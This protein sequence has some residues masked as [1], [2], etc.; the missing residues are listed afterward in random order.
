MEYEELLKQIS[1]FP[2]A[3]DRGKP[4]F[5]L[6]VPPSPQV[7]TPGR[8]FLLKTP[9]EGASY[10]STVLKNAGYGVEIVDYRH[11]SKPLDEVLSGDRIVLGIGTTM[12]SYP[13][14]E[15]F[16]RQVKEKNKDIVIILGGAF[17]SSAPSVLMNSIPADYAVIGEGE[18]TMLE[19]MDALSRPGSRRIPDIPGLAFR[20]N[21]KV[22]FSPA[23]QQ[24]KD[25]DNL[26]IPDFG[27]WP[28]VKSGMNL[29]RLGISSSRGCYGKCSFCFKTIPQVRQ[30]TPARFAELVKYCVK[31]HGLKFA[32]I[33]DLTFVIGRK[34]TVEL[35]RELKKT[36]I[37]WATSTRAQDVDEELLGIL[38]D[39]G[40]REMWYGIESV[41]QSVLDANFKDITVEQIEHAV[42]ITGNAG[43]KVMAN[44]IIGLLG[45]TRES[46]QKMEDF[47]AN[48]KVI[49]CSI[50]YL[51]PF[52]GTHVYKYAREKNL[53]RDE[54]AYFRMLSRRKVNDAQDEIINCTDLPEDV[55]RGAFKKIRAISYQRYGPL[56]WD[57]D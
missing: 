17:V 51:S 4:V 9:T 30:M 50:K 23:R 46:L 32:F 52:P 44:F 7:P 18:L 35:C 42:K 12:D 21:G 19:L 15:E 1:G 29:E 39:C 14:L 20:E 55:L 45:E 33:N 6:I 10:I 2:V 41:D 38:K 25:M 26:P 8:E 5:K 3:L 43:I 36:G 49:P 27:L 24:V 16:T 13:F 53:I 54:L 40:C 34:R 28:A 31:A 22:C 47:I 11:E 57:A 37:I 56:N 48:R